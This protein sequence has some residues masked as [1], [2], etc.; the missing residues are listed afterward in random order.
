MMPEAD[1][2]LVEALEMG[3]TSI[4]GAPNYDTDHPAHINRVFELAR[5]YD[6]HVDLHI[7]SGHDPASD[8]QHAGRGPDR[9]IQIRRPGRDGPHDQGRGA[10]ARQAEGHRASGSPTSA[11]R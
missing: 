11:P 6:I 1:K 7:D 8:G 3:A 9:E 2:A 4:G 5:E 10:A